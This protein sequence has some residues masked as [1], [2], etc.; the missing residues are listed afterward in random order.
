MTRKSLSPDFNHTYQI[1]FI[2]RFAKNRQVLK[3]IS[4]FILLLSFA[5]QAFANQFIALDYYLNTPAYAKNC[6]NKARP[7]LHCN[8]QCQ[9]MKKLAR[10]EKKEQENPE[11]KSAGKNETNL[12]SKS[13]FTTAPETRTLR[14]KNLYPFYQD[15]TT[16]DISSPV[17]HPP[18][19]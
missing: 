9:F 5:V 14:E 19:A 12:S 1:A 16:V 11:N 10:Q 6:V 8:G 17:F 7:M 18:G 3:K 13:F 15:N 4:A 2:I